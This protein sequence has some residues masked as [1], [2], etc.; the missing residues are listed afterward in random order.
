MVELKTKD[1]SEVALFSFHPDIASFDLFYQQFVKLVKERVIIGAMSK[2]SWM[3]TIAVLCW[4]VKVSEIKY[5][6]IIIVTMTSEVTH[7]N[8]SH[9]FQGLYKWIQ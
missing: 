1:I 8:T 6:I 3:I 4:I 9:C 2:I 5:H 7:K